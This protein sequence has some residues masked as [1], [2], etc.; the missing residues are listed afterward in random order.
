MR[1]TRP[2]RNGLVRLRLVD[3][4]H[5]RHRFDEEEAIRRAR[6]LA[7][8]QAKFSHPFDRSRTYDDTQ[9][10]FDDGRVSDSVLVAFG[11]GGD[12]LKVAPVDFFD[13]MADLPVRRIFIR[14]LGA[15]GTRPHGLGDN[16][17]DVSESLARLLAPNRRKIFLGVSLGGFNALLLGALLNATKVIVVDPST[18]WQ[19]E[20][21]QAWEDDRDGGAA[22]ALPATWRAEFGDVPSVWRRV[23]PPPVV[24][25]FPYRNAI[26]R[27]HAEHLAGW[28]NVRLVPH[29]EHMP[30][31]KICEDGSL[32]RW[33]GAA[34]CGTE[35]ESSRV[36]R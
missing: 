29:F 10:V 21:L 22:D 24:V 18:S 31:Y 6:K 32:R 12:K 9:E 3:L 36:W 27:N 34:L 2:N 5:D 4:E 13:L 23:P 7:A 20:H 11:G 15:V 30:M 33:L 25:H 19:D 16:V 14:K 1:D 28:P 17:Q 8:E 35:E 26:L